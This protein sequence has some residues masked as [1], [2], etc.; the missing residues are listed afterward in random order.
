VKI[1]LLRRESVTPIALYLA[2][3]D[4]LPDSADRQIEFA[5]VLLYRERE[6]RS[7]YGSSWWVRGGRPAPSPDS[8]FVPYDITEDAARDL[9]AML[10]DSRPIEAPPNPNDLFGLKGLAVEGLRRTLR[11]RKTDAFG[12]L[13]LARLHRDLCDDTS[14]DA[15]AV[16]AANLGASGDDLDERIRRLAWRLRSAAEGE[17]FTQFLTTEKAFCERERDA[18][19]KAFDETNVPPPLRELIPLARQIGVGDDVCRGLFVRKM[20]ARERRAAAALIAR[21]ATAIDAWLATREP[22]HA[23]EAEAFFWLRAAGEELG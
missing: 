15:A 11:P 7:M 10:D 20:G 23:G 12:W 3:R 5:A 13:V 19:M 17:A 9:T 1:H 16:H 22:P 6:Y 21:H 8:A 2:R 14:A 18:A 4:E